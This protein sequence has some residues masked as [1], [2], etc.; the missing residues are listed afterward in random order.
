MPLWLGAG[1]RNLSLTP[2]FLCHSLAQ[3]QIAVC[4]LVSIVEGDRQFPT[5]LA[6]FSHFAHLFAPFLFHFHE[7]RIFMGK[8]SV[9]G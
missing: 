5:S 7:T 1:W 4:T 9:N 8:N 3:T 6:N 2:P